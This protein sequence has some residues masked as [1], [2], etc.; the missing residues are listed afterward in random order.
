MSRLVSHSPWLQL[1][2]VVDPPLTPSAYD[3]EFESTVLDAGW[4]RL[5]TFDDSTVIDP[6]ASF[7]AVGARWSHNS[8]PSGVGKPS[9]YMIQPADTMGEVNI[10]KA[11][12]FPNEFFAYARMSFCQ[13]NATQTDNDALV[14]M[15]IEKAS[16]SDGVYICLNESD[17]NTIQLEAVVRSGGSPTVVANTNNVGGAAVCQGQHGQ[18]VGIQRL[19]STWHFW[20]LAVS[21]NWVHLGSTTYSGS[22]D[23]V[24]IGAA[25]ASTASPGNLIMGIDFFRYRDGR[26][27]P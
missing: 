12:T 10:Y 26:I 2:D 1:A 25:V 15:R 16:D 22:I 21:G 14:L 13:R 3:D 24:R 4:T 11:I 19:T 18:V 5:G 17:A 20:A 8:V 6:Y 7:S 27:L 9:W 23:R